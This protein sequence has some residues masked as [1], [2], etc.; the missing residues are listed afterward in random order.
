MLSTISRLATLGPVHGLLAVLSYLSR[1]TK[2]ERTV[3][4]RSKVKRVRSR[5]GVWLASNWS[6]STFNMYYFGQYGRFLADMLRDEKQPFVF[7]D[8]GA[9]QGL[10][11]LLAAKNPN[12]RACVAFEPVPDTFALLQ[13]NI[14]ANKLDHIVSAVNYAIAAETGSATIRINPVHS[15]GASMAA[16][17]EVGG[18]QVEIRMIDSVTLDTII[19]DGGEAILVKIDVEGFEPIVV[20]QLVRSSYSHRI[21][22]IFYEV[23]E[24][25]VNPA[26]IE[27]KLR[28][29]GFASFRKIAGNSSTHYDVLATR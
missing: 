23:D 6:D 22:K 29:I 7:L 9:N 19:P 2:L 27:L 5:Y 21:A 26:E 1:S 15:G 4:E 16:S 17:N 12:C 24:T 14:S 20:D 11:S 18:R 3:L 28:S 8:I 25:W 13:R 10:Y